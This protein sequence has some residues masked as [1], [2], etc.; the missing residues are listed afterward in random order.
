MDDT[1]MAYGRSVSPKIVNYIET[2]ILPQYSKNDKAHGLVHIK[3]VV[4]R[5]FVL[6]ETLGLNLNPDMIYVI[7]SYHDIGKFENHEIHEIISA[8]K[9]LADE[10]IK[11][12]FNEG[13]VRCI[14]EAIED[15]RSSSNNHRSI[16]GQLISSAD[17][18]TTVD[19]VFI[20]SF[21]VA[22]ERMPDSP[23]EEYLDYTIQRL[24]KRYSKENPESMVLRDAAYEEFLEEMR[25]I[26]KDP[27]TF[28]TRYCT[29]NN[30][31]NRNGRVKDFSGFI[32]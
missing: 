20:R 11:S 4:R 29:I 8:Q 3:E 15:H 10:K 2:N 14:A 22:Q 17:R 1:I 21:F 23:I 27:P 19:M 6:N 12:F 31:D 5:S 16:Y 18:N 26:L 28:K 32:E 25:A 13:E 30:I 9:F 24:S 7:A